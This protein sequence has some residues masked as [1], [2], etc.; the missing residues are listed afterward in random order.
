MG[1]TNSTQVSYIAEMTYMFLNVYICISY[2]EPTHIILY[3]TLEVIFMGT[4]WLYQ[5]TRNYIQYYLL[6]ILL[7]VQLDTKA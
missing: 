1:V 2:R 6:S 5:F 3:R 4:N 7:Y